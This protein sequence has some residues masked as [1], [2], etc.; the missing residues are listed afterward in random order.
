MAYQLLTGGDRLGIT[1]RMP[2][3]AMQQA[4]LSAQLLQAAKQKVKDWA[5]KNR[6]LKGKQFV[7]T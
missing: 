3:G 4:L 1:A 5:K 6:H 7:S 2:N